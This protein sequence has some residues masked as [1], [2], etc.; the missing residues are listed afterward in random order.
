MNRL[1]L[2]CEPKKLFERPTATAAETE[3]G[4]ITIL[5]ERFGII[6]LLNE[7]RIESLSL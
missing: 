6:T 1:Y 5:P 3:A 2:N 7:S 4:C